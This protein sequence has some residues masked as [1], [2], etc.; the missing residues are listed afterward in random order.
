MNLPGLH[1]NGG[2]RRIS[3][4]AAV[5][6]TACGSTPA[7]TRP[8]PTLPA[9]EQPP[10]I[11][12]G[13]GAA[14]SV[15]SLGFPALVE[16]SGIAI[17]GSGVLWAH[18]DSGSEPRIYAMATDGSPL[19]AVD[20]DARNVDWEDFAAGPGPG[21][22]TYLYLADIGDNLARRRHVTLYRFPE[23]D[24]AAGMVTGL[25][26]IDVTY[27]DGPSDAE[28]LLVDPSTGDAFIV[29]KMPGWGR[30]YEV[31]ASAWGAASVVATDVGA[32]VLPRAD[33]V[34]TGGD[35]SA[36][37]SVVALRT[38]GDVRLFARDP[39]SSVGE[40]LTH[41]SCFLAAAEEDQGE[42]IAFDGTA[43]LTVGEGAAAVIHR[44]GR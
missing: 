35:V 43:L 44:S 11:C 6:V 8:V 20:V 38:Y 30:I 14:V 18:N 29:T 2:V 39:G 16:T 25:E 23:P 17:G 4:V 12:D 40:A 9:A 19:G 33:S 42:A 34:I 28:A 37:G 3:L 21:G 27:P 36:D 22:D 26:S 31:P 41:R 32:A 13:F 7:A 10:A 1:H 24:P 5:L 15:G